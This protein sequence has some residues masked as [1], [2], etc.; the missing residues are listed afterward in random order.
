MLGVGIGIGDCGH[1][2]ELSALEA[3]HVILFLALGIRNDDH[4]TQAKR[5]AHQGKAD[6]GIS[7]G[8]FDHDPA[9]LEPAIVQRIHDD[10]QRRPILHR[11]AGIHEFG[12]AQ[13]RAAGRFR[14]AL[15]LD[16]RSVADGLDDSI[17]NLHERLDPAR[18]PE[19]TVV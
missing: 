14:C 18:V 6:A 13:N 16:Q 12:L 11:L 5:V 10:E 4:A 9:A 7:G 2:D 3:Q 15:E 17:A 19:G 1:F 8:A